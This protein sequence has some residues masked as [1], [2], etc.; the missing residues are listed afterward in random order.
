VLELAGPHVDVVRPAP[1][2]GH[3]VCSNRYR[4][5]ALQPGQVAASHAWAIHPDRREQ[6][7]RALVEARTAPLTPK[8]LAGFL[9]D[10]IDPADPGR[11]P[12]QLGGIL[13]QPL[14]VHCVVVAPARL[15]AH[16][17]IDRAPC[18]EGAWAELSWRWEGPIGGWELDA[19]ARSGFG[20]RVLH[21]FVPPHSAASRHV[22]DATRAYEVDHDVAAARAAIEQAVAAEPG[23]PSLRLAAAWL[24]LEARLVERALVHIE[25]GLAHENEPYRRGQLLLWGIRAAKRDEKLARRWRDELDTLRGDGVDELH[26]QA[27]RRHS[28]IPHANLM[29][30][31]AY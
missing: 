3:L 8:D 31:D 27:L 12:R 22:H 1:G 29:M 23:D 25:A 26:A 20:A 13:A 9:G 2:T 18:C 7:L 17:G 6:R 28:G 19:P 16:L 10:R 30:V 11:R 21:D 24:A 5:G 4:S 15:R 14:N